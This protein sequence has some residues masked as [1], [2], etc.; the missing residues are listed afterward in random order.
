MFFLKLKKNVY[1]LIIKR[2]THIYIFFPKEKKMKIGNY[3]LF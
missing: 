3:S 2:K 1:A